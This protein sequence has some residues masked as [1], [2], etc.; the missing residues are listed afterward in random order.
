AFTSSSSGQIGG[1]GLSVTGT[2]TYVAANGDELDGTFSGESVIG[3]GTVTGTNVVTIT[4]G[5][6]RFADAIGSFHET[7]SGTLAFPGNHIQRTGAPAASGGGSG[8]PGP[9]GNH[10]AFAVSLGGAGT[11]PPLGGTRPVRHRHVR[12]R[13]VADPERRHGQEARGQRRDDGEEPV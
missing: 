12:R 4:G 11:A 5:T 1:S 3:T 8:G 13:P 6:G 2:E 10:G 7:F 9:R